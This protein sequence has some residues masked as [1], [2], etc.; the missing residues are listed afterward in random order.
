MIANTGTERCGRPAA[1]ESVSDAHRPHSLQ[2]PGSDSS[3]TF[4]LHSLPHFLDLESIGEFSRL[5]ELISIDS[6]CELLLLP[7]VC[8][9]TLAH[10]LNRFDVNA[11]P[12]AVWATRRARNL[13]CLRIVIDP[14]KMRRSDHFNALALLRIVFKIFCISVLG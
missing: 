14:S 1:P 12:Q 13:L 10:K 2:S 6:D 7:Q 4:S 3:S 8:L 9:H 11:V 5:K